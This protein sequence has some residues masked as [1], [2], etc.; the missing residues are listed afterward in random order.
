MI[1]FK[2]ATEIRLDLELCY[3]L[4]IRRYDL[5]VLYILYVD[6]PGEGVAG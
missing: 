2:S 6:C 4:D 3:N 5:E 1:E